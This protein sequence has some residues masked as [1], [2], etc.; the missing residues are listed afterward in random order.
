VLFSERVLTRTCARIYDLPE[1]TPRLWDLDEHGGKKPNKW[2]RLDRLPEVNRLTI[3]AFERACRRVGLR[4]A[5]R[6]IAGFGGSAASRLT[7]VLTRV[8]GVREFFSAYV[9]YELTPASAVGAPE[10]LDARS[11]DSP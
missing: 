8:P 4:I 10:R 7:R 9:I 3:H 1:F 5:R 6:E 11:G 2:H